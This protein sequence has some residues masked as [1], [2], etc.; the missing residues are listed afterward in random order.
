[1][2]ELKMIGT[3]KWFNQVKGYGYI[4]GADE[5]EYYFEIGSLIDENDVYKKGDIV[6][7]VPNFDDINY[8]TSVEKKVVEKYESN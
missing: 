6:M 8:A 5:S 7:F 3:I 4:I 1:M 2:E